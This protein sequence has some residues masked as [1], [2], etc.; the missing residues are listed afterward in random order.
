MKNITRNEFQE[1]VLDKDLVIVDFWA[2][3]CN[4]CKTMLPILERLETEVP[5]LNIVKV[6]ADE[7]L[8]LLQEYG[9]SSIPTIIV[10]KQGEIA[11]TL[12]GAKPFGMMIEEIKPYV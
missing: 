10:F 7:N 12:V 6:N 5:S 11:K 4:P 2:T 3:W 1:E 9:V 8:D